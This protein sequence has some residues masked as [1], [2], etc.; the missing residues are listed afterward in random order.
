MAGHSL[1]SS[2]TTLTTRN[3]DCPDFKYD[4]PS[5]GFRCQMSPDGSKVAVHQNW[6]LSQTYILG[7]TSASSADITDL[8][9]TSHLTWFP[10][11]KR[12]AYLRSWRCTHG[13]SCDECYDLVVQHLASGQITTIH[14]WYSDF[15]LLNKILVTP[16]GSRVITCKQTS[17]QCEFR[18]W[19]VSDL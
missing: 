4:D 19:D 8:K 12:I 3:I 1:L 16:D 17:D 5:S 6:W 7:I 10:D 2:M 18:T 9:D 14:R 13:L 15:A 11:S